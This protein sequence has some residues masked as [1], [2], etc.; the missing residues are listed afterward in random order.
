MSNQLITELPG[1][2]SWY[3]HSVGLGT[4][5]YDNI[6][7]NNGSITGASWIKIPTGEYV[8]DYESSSV[9]YVNC[10]NISAVSGGNLSI[11]AWIKKESDGARQQIVCKATSS[12]TADTWF[13]AIDATNVLRFQFTPVGNE[14]AFSSNTILASDGWTFVGATYDGTTMRVYINGVEDGTHSYS[15]ITPNN[16]ENLY[17]GRNQKNS[18]SGFD[19]LIGSV[20]L[21]NEAWSQEIFT[22]LYK[23]TYRK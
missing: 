6:S 4:T 15:G 17:I 2:V 22:Q 11:A 8:L 10:G 16:G 19:G 5:L 21:S 14:L 9:N 1:L 7:S 12:N 23:K 13:F 20:F 3:P 18:V